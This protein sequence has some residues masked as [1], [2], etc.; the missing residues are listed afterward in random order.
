MA[1]IEDTIQMFLTPDPVKRHKPRTRSN[2][3]SRYTS[4]AKNSLASGAI[5]ESKEEGV[6]IMVLKKSNDVG[7]EGDAG[8]SECVHRGECED[9]REGRKYHKKDRYRRRYKL[10]GE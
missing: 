3:T 6:D 8:E 4:P 7:G 5:E 10:H 9:V 1:K 2:K